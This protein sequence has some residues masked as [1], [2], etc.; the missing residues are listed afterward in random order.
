MNRFLSLVGFAVI[1]AAIAAVIRRRAIADYL[2][3]MD[4]DEARAKIIERTEPRMGAE[5]AEEIADKVIER[6][7]AAGKLA[8]DAADKIDE[9][10]EQVEEAAGDAADEAADA[11]K[12]AA[13][14][15][16]NATREAADEV[17]S[18]AD[19]AADKVHDAVDE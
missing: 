18:A 3:G 2:T 5:R 16:A 4:R 10:V 17:K 12:S 1:A 19:K 6:L 8:T 13:D 7:D 9:V 15:A 14:K 11:T